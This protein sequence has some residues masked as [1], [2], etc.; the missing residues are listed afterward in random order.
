MNAV[1]IGW[2]AFWRKTSAHPDALRSAARL[3]H[4]CVVRTACWLDL[5]ALSE[6]HRVVYRGPVFI[7]GQSTGFLIYTR[8]LVL[9]GREK[10]EKAGT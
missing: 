9:L 1:P 3:V 7:L 2:H 5:V 8:N 4:L 10:R 6:W